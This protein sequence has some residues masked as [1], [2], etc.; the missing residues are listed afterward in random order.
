MARVK[1]C[2]VCEF[3][4]KPV[5]IFCEKDGVS[6]IDVPITDSDN[7]PQQSPAAGPAARPQTPGTRREEAWLAT[8]AALE[9]PWGMVEVTGRLPVGRDPDFSPV[10]D[11]L[12]DYVS[13]R[14][15]EVF[16]EGS[17]LYVRHIGTTNPTYVN[18]MPIE[19]DKPVQLADG[20]RV[21][22]SWH[23]TAIAR[24]G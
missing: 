2:P 3:Q 16:L 9:F 20:D 1:V 8:R 7:G 5:E 11:R 13:Q 24:L 23:M 10:A 19:R 4:N 22:F 21:N 15:A 17:Q 14:H 18:G 6:L 12:N